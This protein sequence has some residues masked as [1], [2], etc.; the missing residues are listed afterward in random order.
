VTTTASSTSSVT[1]PAPP[2]TEQ[3]MAIC[4]AEVDA[5]QV[6]TPDEKAKLAGYCR[7]ALTSPSPDAPAVIEAKRSICLTIV[8]DSGVSGANAVAADR[9]CEQIGAA[10]D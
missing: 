4:V 8:K 2:T 7:T 5:E 6:L 3:Q 1:V 9:A 10:G